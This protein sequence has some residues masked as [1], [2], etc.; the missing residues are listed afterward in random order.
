MQ[1]VQFPVCIVNKI[2]GCA[3]HDSSAL[4]ALSGRALH[5]TT[6]H[7][8]C[9]AAALAFLCISI[10]GTYADA[11]WQGLA[12]FRRRSKF[13]QS[14]H[15]ARICKSSRQ[16]CC[17]AIEKKMA[18]CGCMKALQKHFKNVRLAWTHSPRVKFLASQDALEVMRVTY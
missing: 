17:F 11:G 2:V 14:F 6:R 5:V 18:I 9:P 16:K 1:S 15:R 10:S 3:K 4:S 12:G 7:Y 8:R 13:P